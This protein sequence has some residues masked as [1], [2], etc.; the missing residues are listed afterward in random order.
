MTSSD[1]SIIESRSTTTKILKGYFFFN[2]GKNGENIGVIKYLVFGL[3]RGI[4]SMIA[5]DHLD[6]YFCATGMKC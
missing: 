5:Q 2:Y 1:L 3:K 6:F 4:F